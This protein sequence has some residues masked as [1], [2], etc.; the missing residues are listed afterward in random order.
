MNL[1]AW[2]NPFTWFGSKP[3]PDAILCDY[4]GCGKPL[5]KG[6]WVNYDIQLGKLYHSDRACGVEAAVERAELFQEEVQMNLSCI[7]LEEAVKLRAERLKA[8]P[9][10]GMPSGN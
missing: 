7:S 6:R 2:Y 8:Q 4:S 5:P 3:D 1:M 10:A 9:R